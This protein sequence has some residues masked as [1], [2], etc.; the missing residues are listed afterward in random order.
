METGDVPAA[1]A[2]ISLT[3]NREVQAGAAKRS[4]VEELETTADEGSGSLLSEK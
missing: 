1:D 3:I 2:T 4:E